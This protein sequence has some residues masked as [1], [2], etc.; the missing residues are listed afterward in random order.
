MTARYLAIEP[1]QE[2]L[3]VGLD[4]NR[5]VQFVFNVVATKRPS[6]RFTQEVVAILVGAGVGVAGTSIFTSSKSVVPPGGG[7]FISIRA[8]GGAGPIGTHNG[9]ANAYRRPGAQI[10]VRG[11]SV[12]QTEAMVWNAFDALTAIRN[13]AVTA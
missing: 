5:R 4:E 2:P 6:R 1:Q 3:D 9:G 12:T 8:T 10:L 11:E 7:P 13:E